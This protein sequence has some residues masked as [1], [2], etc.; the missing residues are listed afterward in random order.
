VAHHK[1]ALKRIKQTAKKTARNRA[2][3][4]KV[5]KAVRAF[6]TANS[7]SDTSAAELLLVNAI[8]VVSKA[9]SKGV[10]PAKR[11]SRK[12]SRLM[13]QHNRANA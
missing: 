1:S 8:K 2:G 7:S 4:T 6:R 13:K 12:I 5:K 3:R 10:I 9:A 11:A